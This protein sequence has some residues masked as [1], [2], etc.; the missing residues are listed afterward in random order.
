MILELCKNSGNNYYPQKYISLPFWIWCQ[1]HSQSQ[2][3]T[4]IIKLKQLSYQMLKTYIPNKLS[5]FQA[6][7]AEPD[8]DD[9]S[10]FSQVQESILFIK[11]TTNNYC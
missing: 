11:V 2:V 6:I 5:I 1:W 7:T 3:I 8:S 10:Q 9:E 4:H